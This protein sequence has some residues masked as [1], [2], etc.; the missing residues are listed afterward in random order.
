[1]RRACTAGPRTTGTAS[2]ILPGGAHAL[3]VLEH[4]IGGADHLRARFDAAGDL[5]VAV[6]ADADGH[7]A[8]VDTAPIDDPDELVARGR[9]AEAVGRHRHDTAPRCHGEVDRHGH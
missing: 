9:A 1:G 2:A 7:G 6:T 4:T 3:A 5:G 8:T